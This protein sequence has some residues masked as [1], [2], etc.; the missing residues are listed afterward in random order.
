MDIFL[1]K[2]TKISFYLLFIIVPLILTPWNYELFEFNK[3]LTVYA[4]TT[5]IVGAWLGRM[6][7]TKKIIFKRT[8]FDI[9]LLLF[10][11]SQFLSFLVSIDR[12]T[13]FWGYYSRFHGGL[14]STICYLL[15]YW[16]FV[17]FA[18]SQMGTNDN[19][20]NPNRK[21][22]GTIRDNIRDNSGDPA[23][24][25]KNCLYVSLFTAL[26]VSSY[27]ILEHYGI[28]ANLWIQDVRNRVFSTLG[29]PNWLAA[30]LAVLIP[31]TL[32]FAFIENIKNQ[33]V[34]IHSKYQKFLNFNMYIYY[35]Q[36]CLKSSFAY[37]LFT[38]Y[39]LCFLYTKSQSGLLG[40]GISLIIFWP[41]L[42]LLNSKLKFTTKKNLLFFF[43]IFSFLIFILFLQVGLKAYP[44]IADFVQKFGLIKKTALKSETTIQSTSAY[45][46]PALEIGG[47]ASG[48]IR[49]I[50]WK[51]ALEIWKH[52]PIFG[53]GVETFAYSYYNFRPIEHNFVSEWD[54]LYNKAHNEYLNF[55]ATTGIVG[56]GSYLIFI[57]SFIF[58]FF[59]NLKSQMLNLKDKKIS[60]LSFGFEFCVL[61]F[62]LF[63]GWISILI[64]NF[65]GF[66]VVPV[67]LF[68]FL[69]PAFCVALSALN[70][71]RPQL[72]ITNYSVTKIQ[73]LSLVILLFTIFYL[74]FTIT[75]LWRAD[76]HYALGEKLNKTRQYP[77]AFQEL[78]KAIK[79]NKGEPVYR[80]E[81]AESAANLSLLFLQEKEATSAS[82]MAQ[83][84]LSQ[85]E[86]AL[87]VS[88]RN[89]NFWK[90]RVKVLYNLSQIDKNFAPLVIS[91]LRQATEL[92]P[93]DPKLVYNLGVI[94]SSFKQNQ[95]AIDSFKKAIELKPNYKDPRFALALYLKEAGKKEEAKEQLEYILKNIS[96]DD[97]PSGKLLKELE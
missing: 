73:K 69:I 6:I 24:F 60:D 78:T 48:E 34:K 44:Q 22:F 36:A 49:R 95:E 29:Q 27:G 41:I 4:L 32:G 17:S 89:L 37:L 28:D 55:L 59:K 52:Y 97:S 70:G 45:Q 71:S 67:A 15:L 81:I 91:S 68:F 63:S 65:F 61:S 46:A 20:I 75:N 19:R 96:P 57:L 21:T 35:F 82:K 1:Q 76:Y 8:P 42:F 18:Y 64:T 40:L 84:A 26:L 87:R 54:F 23:T 80:N 11:I 3:M 77:T 13:S 38:I 72:L 7:L 10:L 5:I 43:F 25:V 66:S 62:A 14:L 50:V 92:A 16:A 39:Y 12:H 90:G 51:G 83:I 93:T 86:E 33:K 9:P 31:I 56:L 94:Y 47:T 88:P 53:S 74:L 79:L 2:T 30:W 58:W 85:S